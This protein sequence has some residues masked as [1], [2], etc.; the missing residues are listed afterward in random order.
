MKNQIY[1]EGDVCVPLEGVTQSN[2]YKFKNLKR[3]KFLHSNNLF[4]TFE[5]LEGT[6]DNYSLYTWAFE[7]NEITL[8]AGTTRLEQSTYSIF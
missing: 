4:D 2:C 5:I 3:L 6:S 8:L 7:G 1:K